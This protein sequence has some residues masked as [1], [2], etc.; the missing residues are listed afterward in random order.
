MAWE[1][2]GQSGSYF[3]RSVRTPEGVRKVYLGKGRE[4]HLEAE[5][6]AA[7][8]AAQEAEKLALQAERMKTSEA[9]QMTQ[10]LEEYSTL[11]LEA[12]LLAA[13]YWRGR[14]YRR[15]RKRRAVQG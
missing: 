14:D 9:E 8:K 2:R 13:G 6:I 4:A 5:R 1:R 15:W 3:Y 12:S 11:L 7:S 10:D